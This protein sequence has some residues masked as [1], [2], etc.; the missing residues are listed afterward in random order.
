MTPKL[1]PVILLVDDD[2]LIRDLGQ[3]LLEHLGYRVETA[4]DGSEALAKY[5]RLGRADLVVLD[6][7]LPGQ[8]GREVLKEFRILDKRARVL[9]ASGFLSSLDMA[10]LKAEGALGLINK[11]YR[12]TDLQHRIKAVLAGRSGF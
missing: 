12:L 8:N 7:C 1:P 5:R 6:Y 11:P 3:E 2:P 4:G 10:G 9:V